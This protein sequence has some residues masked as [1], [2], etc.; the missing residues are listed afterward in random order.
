VAVDVVSS[1]LVGRTVELAR[2]RAALDRTRAGEPSVVLVG[3]EAGVGKSRLLD[4]A[5]SDDDTV[6][7]LTGGC[8][9]LGGDGLPFV[10]LVEALRTLVR[11]APAADVDRWLGPARS[12]LGRLLPELLAPGA[13]AVAVSGST[14]QL[15]ELLLG[16]LAGGGRDRPGLRLPPC[17]DP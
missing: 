14:A 1:V 8:I 3:G 9:E 17:L 6:R 5:L 11:T 2:L 10:P 7:V 15:F 16:V 13:S 12:E 4:A